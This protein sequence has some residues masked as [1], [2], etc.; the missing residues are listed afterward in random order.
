[1]T[2]G[3]YDRNISFVTLRYEPPSPYFPTNYLLTNQG[4]G[5]TVYRQTIDT[6]IAG[7][8]N[9]PVIRTANVEGSYGFKFWVVTTSTQCNIQPTTHPEQARRVN[10]MACKPEWWLEGGKNVH[11]PSGDITINIPAGFEDLVGPA[12]AAAASW[13]A[14]LG[15]KVDVVSNQPCS[16][17]RCVTVNENYVNPPPPQPQGCADFAG[18]NYNTSTGEWAST[19][20]IRLMPAWRTAHPN[21]NQRSIA[22]ELGHYFG[23]WNRTQSPC[24]YPNTV[25]SA[26]P[27]PGC[28]DSSAPPQDS[29]LGPTSSDA[30]ALKESTYGN[31][32]RKLC[33]W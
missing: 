2:F 31:Q 20:T 30:A 5:G 11:P 28:Y 26:P 9:G 21:R 10:V 7:S 15:R 4:A 32:N 22:H 13:S 19:G 8:T 6:S 17:G 14:A 18:G 12:K 3:T 1:V 29:A 25:M 24:A 27:G 33:G 23:L 16:G